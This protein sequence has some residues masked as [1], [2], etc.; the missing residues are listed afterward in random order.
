MRKTCAASTECFRLLNQTDS[1]VRADSLL[2]LFCI[3]D[4]RYIRR[5]EGESSEFPKSSEFWKTTRKLYICDDTGTSTWN[6]FLPVHLPWLP[7][8]PRSPVRVIGPSRSSRPE[9]SRYH[10][11]N[12]AYDLEQQYTELEWTKSLHYCLDRLRFH[13]IELDLFSEAD[14]SVS[15]PLDDTSIVHYHHRNQG[16]Q[17]PCDSFLFQELTSYYG[18][19]RRRRKCVVRF[20]FSKRK[21]PILIEFCDPWAKNVLMRVIRD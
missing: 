5:G 20:Y 14:L 9:Q 10:Q 4:R 13:S 8:S 1:T 11:C 2:T 3:P 21:Q 12:K 15:T 7:T 18:G 6:T 16:N 19:T 17:S